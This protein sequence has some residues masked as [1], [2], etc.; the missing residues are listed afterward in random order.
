MLGEGMVSFGVPLVA[1]DRRNSKS[2]PKMGASSASSPT[3][4]STRRAAEVKS[5]SPW[6]L[7]KCTW[8]F[9]SVRLIP[10]SR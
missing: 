1:T 10:R 4:P 7:W 2:R 6:A 3:F 8:I 9:S 5:R